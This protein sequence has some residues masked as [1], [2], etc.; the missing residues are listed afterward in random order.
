MKWTNEEIEQYKHKCAEYYN[1]RGGNQPIH[2][3]LEENP[4]TSYFIPNEDERFALSEK[5]LSYCSDFVEP[6]VDYEVITP[7]VGKPYAKLKD[8]CGDYLF[9]QEYIAPILWI[10]IISQITGERFRIPLSS[11]ISARKANGGD[12]YPHGDVNTYLITAIKE[13]KPYITLHELLDE[14]VD[15]IG[16]NQIYFTRE[17]Y[18][19]G[20]KEGWI[21]NC[22]L[23]KIKKRI[24]V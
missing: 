23:V 12:I 14:L 9:P 20:L 6:D 13:S 24:K 19:N 2:K 22:H 10:E 4:F 21:E 17:Q 15:Y 7:W 11:M 1:G 18:Y 8:K 3:F 16:N 5:P